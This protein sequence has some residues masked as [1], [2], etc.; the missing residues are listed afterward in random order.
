[1]SW[2]CYW[3]VTLI[4]NKF[5][6]LF[7]AFGFVLLLHGF[8]PSFQSSIQ[9]YVQYILTLT[10]K[11]VGSYGDSP[12]YTWDHPLCDESGCLNV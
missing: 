10:F 2:I 1:M 5:V 9:S 4:P 3:N 11:F 7:H 8:I 12:A 6:V